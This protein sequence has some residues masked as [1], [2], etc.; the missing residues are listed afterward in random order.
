MET[1]ESYG[2]FWSFPGH[3]GPGDRGLKGSK[4]RRGAPRFVR[5][6]A[7]PAVLRGCVEV[8]DEWLRMAIV[9]LIRWLLVDMVVNLMDG[10]MLD[11]I[12]NAVVDM[13]V[14]SMVWCFV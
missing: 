14:D 3:P 10:R 12:S 6:K 11:M 7:T 1:H 9:A 5:D 4:P 8:S 2:H 13:V